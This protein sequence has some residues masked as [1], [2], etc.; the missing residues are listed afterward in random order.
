MDFFIFPST[1]NAFNLRSGKIVNGYTQATWIE[2][3]RDAS[4]FTIEA[5]LDSDIR[6]QMPIGSL[7]S[8][9][10]TDEVLI[11]ED[12]RLVIDENPDIR[13]KIVVTGR[14]FETFLENRVVGSNQNWASSTF[15][16]PA[17]QLITNR[18]SLTARFLIANHIDYQDLLDDNDAL[19]YVNTYLS[20][21]ISDLYYPLYVPDEDDTGFEKKDVYNTVLDLLGIDNLG[22]TTRRNRSL[23]EGFY[24]DALDVPTRYGPDNINLCIYPGF[25]RSKSVGFSYA[26]GDVRNAEYLFSNRPLKTSCMVSS[27][28]FSVMIH[29]PEDNYAR[30]VMPLDASYLDEEYETIPTGA[31]RTKILATLK[32]LGRSALAKQKKVAMSSVQL[33]QDNLSIKYRDQYGLGDYISVYGDYNASTVL[34]VTE[35]VEIVDANG[36]IAYPTLE[37]P[38]A[39]GYHDPPEF[40][41]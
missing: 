3:F 24:D 26:A 19:P 11:V 28:Y 34:Q 16:K 15:P 30:R 35:H 9:T 8:H 40:F 1:S 41:S 32:K 14:G 33:S 39:G 25:D 12:H 5:P 6:E 4:E 13:D 17:Y 29:G 36:Y 27:R 10:D 37:E 23:V 20:P 2:R 21:W 31:T 22:F 18:A 38:P 7:I